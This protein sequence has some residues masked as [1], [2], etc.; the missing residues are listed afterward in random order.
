MDDENVTLESCEAAAV[1]LA[2]VEATAFDSPSTLPGLP[3]LLSG[4]FG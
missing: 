4:A 3:S 2:D 1:D